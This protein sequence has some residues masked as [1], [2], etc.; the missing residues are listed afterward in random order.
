LS[1][2]GELL[3]AQ[4]PKF[5]GKKI[6]LAEAIE[7]TPSRLTRVIE[8]EFSLNEKNCLRLA[9]AS[10]LPAKEVLEAAGKGD[11]AELIERAYGKSDEAITSKERDHL[12]LWRAIGAAEQQAIELLVRGLR[13]GTHAELDLDPAARE[14]VGLFSALD[15]EK[16][17]VV[18]RSVQRLA[19]KKPSAVRTDRH[20]PKRPPRRRANH[21]G[22]RDPS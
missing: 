14:L 12:N 5:G 2:L 20:D 4:L 1:K 16:Q 7:L 18:I 6:R 22:N 9:L 11:I 15:E 21:G 19:G 3:L 8:G 13:D 17:G 10:G